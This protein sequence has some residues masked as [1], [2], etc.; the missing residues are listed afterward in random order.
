[1]SETPVVT[2]F[3]RNR[4]EVLLLRRSD[5]VG[6]Y[7]GQW[8]AV[9]GHAEG[10]PDGAAR[11]EIREETGLGDAVSFVRAGEPFAVE[12]DRETHWRVHPYLF[13]CDSRAVET[14]YETTE[15]AWV[16]PTE[17]RRRE[18]VPDLR[19]SYERVAPTVDTVKTDADHGSAYLSVRALEVLRDR[20]GELATM[21]ADEA[22]GWNDLAAL[23]L[24]LREARPS[25]VAIENRINRAMADASQTPEGVETAT[26]QG[27]ERALD[28]DAYAAREAAELLAGTVL[29]LS[30]S[31]TV[32]DALRQSAIEDAIVAESR[33]ACEGV[34]VA[35][36]LAEECSVTLVTDA[37]AA[38]VLAEHAV[39][40]VLVGADTVLP[41]G[42]VSNK[43]G[44]RGV[45][46][47]AAN[48]DIPVYAV[49]ASDKIST[50]ADARSERGNPESVYN[51]DA[52]IEVLNPTF[53]R[54]PAEFLT[55]VTEDGPLSAAVVGE[56][57][58]R[59]AALASWPGS[60]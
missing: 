13:D 18:T 50:D 30:R 19:E 1:M 28:A 29:T 5:N 4:G 60:G 15:F 39:D 31:G 54:T 46:I 24:D 44:T 26:R 51:G 21:D 14:N 20:A 23:A 53:D 22:D 41:D 11:E 2:C 6:S 48:E 55:V 59:L 8:G 34:G 33:P 47:A 45:A 52:A 56:H 57:A 38:H 35:E 27:I 7:V 37:A 43:V 9:A 58:E 17:I 40:S 12:D 49:A 3:L 42:S 36:T 25:M 16:P 10:D 32:Q